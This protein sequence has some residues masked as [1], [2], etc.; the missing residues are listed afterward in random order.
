MNNR[1]ARWLSLVAISLLAILL[2]ACSDGSQKAG[3]SNGNETRINIVAKDFSYSLDTSQTQAGKTTF[4]VQN[5]GSVP[6]DFAI[7][8]NGVEQKTPMIK[9]GESATL[10]IDLEPGTY[11]YVCTIPGHEQLGMRGTFTVTSN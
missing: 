9:P 4:I 1:F 3:E 5:N 11:N 10:T 8:G 7:H 6:H 2:T